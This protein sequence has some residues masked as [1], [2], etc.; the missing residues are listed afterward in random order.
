M[1][2]CIPCHAAYNA[3]RKQAKRDEVLAKQRIYD[4]LPHRVL[5]RQQYRASARGIEVHR[6]ACRTYSRFKRLTSHTGD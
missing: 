2:I 3:E 6:R 1:G 4:R 5:A